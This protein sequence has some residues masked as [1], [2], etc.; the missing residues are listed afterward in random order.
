MRIAVIGATGMVGSRIVA[1]A[2]DRG[3]KVTAVSRSAS[4][5]HRSPVAPVRADASRAIDLNAVLNG[6]EAVVLT[7]RVVP[8]E[9]DAFITIT[10]A[11]LAAS[12]RAGI[13]LFIVGGAGPLHSPKDPDRLVVDNP[14]FVPTKWRSTAA[15]SLAQLA[16]CTE[17]ANQNWTYLSPPAILEPGVRIGA[18]RRGTTT[19]LTDHNGRSHISAEDLAVAVIDEL[20]APGADQHITIAMK[21]PRRP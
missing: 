7:V 18:Y 4:A 5:D 11:T 16:T 10:E 6:A 2:A 1:E 9:E 17:H 8:C 15:A 19:L 12:A 14:A 21:P 3:H 13:P 20:E